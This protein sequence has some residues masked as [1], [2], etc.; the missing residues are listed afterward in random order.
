[1]Q[2]QVDRRISDVETALAELA[3]DPGLTQAQRSAVRGC[4][5]SIQGVVL[6]RRHALIRPVPPRRAPAVDFRSRQL[7][8]GDREG[9]GDDAA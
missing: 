2:M 7:P 3:A 8:V 4:L 6:M 9:G 1:M 5:G